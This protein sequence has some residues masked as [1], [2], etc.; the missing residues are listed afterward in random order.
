[1]AAV[2]LRQLAAQ[3]FPVGVPVLTTFPV[4]QGTA[5]D[6]SGWKLVWSDEF[7]GPSIDL[8]KWEHQIGI[9]QGGWGNNELEYYTA[10]PENSR[11]EDGKLII[12][13]RKEIYN[14]GHIA[15]SYTSARMRTMNQGDWKFGRLEIRAKVPQGQGIWPAIWMLPTDNVYGT[16][17]AS[18]EIDIM[19]LVGHEP[20]KVHGTLHYG[21]E[22]PRHLS[23]GGSY[24]LPS[25][26]FSDDFHVFVLEW[27]EREM[28]WYVDDIHFLTQNSWHSNSA[29]TPA[30]FPAPFDQRFHLLLNVAVGG[31]WPGIPDSTTVFPQKM[32]VDYVR[33]YQ[34][35]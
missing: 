17:A 24:T 16:W 28:R 33:V 23:S 32:E 11:I 14:D 5:T 21:G 15:R 30:P 27:E 18:G 25:G 29:N 8:T 6:P 34:R 31:N 4:V 7:D 10:R 13:A 22:W 35:D 12:E 2:T 1:M 19:E 9:G 3:A 20:N 26:T